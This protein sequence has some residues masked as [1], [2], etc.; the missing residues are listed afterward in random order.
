MRAAKTLSFL[1]CLPAESCVPTLVACS[2][3]RRTETRSRIEQHRQ[4]AGRIVAEKVGGKPKVIARVRVERFQ[5]A[6]CP[7]RR[8]TG[9]NETGGKL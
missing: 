4:V 7:G 1:L 2:F 6:I 3:D 5:C 8:L 9:R